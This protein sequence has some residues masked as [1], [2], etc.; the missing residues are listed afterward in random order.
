MKKNDKIAILGYGLEGKSLVQYLCKNSY[1]SVFIH[2][3]KPDL[4]IIENVQKCLGKDYLRALDSYDF[5]FRSPGIPYLSGE[6]SDYRERI[7]S[8]TNLFFEKCPAKIIGVTGTKGKGTT[9]TLIAE[10][11]KVEGKTVWLGGNIGVPALS[12]L[13]KIKPADWVVLEL[14]S[15]QLQDLKYSPYIGIILMT[16]KEHQ[17][18]HLNINEYKEAKKNIISH[19]K[20]D[21]IAIINTMYESGREYLRAVKGRIFEINCGKIQKNGAY[22]DEKSFIVVKDNEKHK[23]CPVSQTKLRGKHNWENICAAAMAAYLSGVKLNAIARVIR[24]FEGLPHRLQ[25]VCEKNGISFINDSFSTAPEPTIAAI[26]AFSE[27][28]ILIIGGSEKGHDYLE[29]ARVI[30]NAHQIK[31]VI[32]L[33]DNAA[34]LMRLA[35][36][37]ESVVATKKI[38][39]LEQRAEIL[40]KTDKD[41]PL[42]LAAAASMQE[43]IL[44]ARKDAMAGDII[45]LSPAAASF[46]LFKDYKERGWV[47]TELANKV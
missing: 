2:D 22:V 30:V 4:R 5:I 47:F 12:F 38:N 8:A 31:K 42:K 11:L 45:L 35:V 7:T 33:G 27:P 17:D 39:R 46:D 9:S 25:K 20:A 29:L 16:T 14:S 37:K 10:M 13:D 28:I 32:F 44:S 40:T 23:I 36:E 19:Q 24:D 1:N 21:D 18:H 15:F 3:R 26:N 34:K 41:I 43:A 6:F